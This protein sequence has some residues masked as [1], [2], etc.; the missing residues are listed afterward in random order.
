MWN[1]FGQKEIDADFWPGQSTSKKLLGKW[2]LHVSFSTAGL[3]PGSWINWLCELRKISIR[4]FM[5]RKRRFFWVLV[6]WRCFTRAKC[7]KVVFRSVVYKLPAWKWFI[8]WFAE[9]IDRQNTGM[10]LSLYY[11]NTAKHKNT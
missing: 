3:H 9:D 6:I 5:S 1:L 7:G 4:W 10:W 2:G 8:M 11:Q